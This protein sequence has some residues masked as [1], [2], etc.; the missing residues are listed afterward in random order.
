MFSSS[1]N[2][3][4]QNNKIRKSNI[5][6][7]RIICIFF[8][9]LRHYSTY[10]DLSSIPAG[11]WSWQ[12]LL[13]QLNTIGAPTANNLFLLISGYYL[14]NKNVN[15]KRVVSLIAEMTFYS[16]LILLILFGF[17][18]IPFSFKELIK[19]LFPVWFG[20]NWYV[21]CYII[22][23]CFIPFIN[24]FLNGLSKEKYQ[25]LLLVS[26]SIWSV[27]YTF[28]ATTYL[29]TDYSLDHF[30]I[31]YAL[32]GYI[33]KY[34]IRSTKASWRT[35]FIISCLLLVISVCGMSYGGAILGSNTLISHA[36]YFSRGTN[37]LDVVVATT[38]FLWIINT[39]PFYNKVINVLAKSV[40]GVFLLHDN[41][42]LR[43]VIWG[44]ISPNAEFIDSNLLPL[45]CLIKVFSVFII[46]F[47]I[48]QLR[49]LTV[50]KMFNAFLDN[51]WNK[52]SSK[53]NS[54][55]LFFRKFIP[56]E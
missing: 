16:W 28:K 26:I 37:I 23:C 11:E 14:I 45:H 12:L 10:V 3:T 13:L 42:L 2:L 48:D 8:I 50:D 40:V 41:P 19:G 56:L 31:I 34:G 17:R 25:K 18:I 21:C 24:P 35:I 33:R 7:L 27:A 30:V 38:L 5:E 55:Y 29:G 22:L 20:Y 46:C 32:G 43:Q 51:N 53:L 1:P 49:L 52:I 54:V 4:D 47:A 9:I 6:L 44:M 15:W 36:T 39:K